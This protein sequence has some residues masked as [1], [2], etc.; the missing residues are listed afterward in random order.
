M[1]N[2]LTTLEEFAYRSNLSVSECKW[3]YDKIIENN[4]DPSNFYAIK[5]DNKAILV[6]K[7]TFILSLIIDKIDYYQVDIVKHEVMGECAVAK[8]KRKDFSE[9]FIW[10]FPLASYKTQYEANKYFMLRKACLV[11][12]ARILF[13]DVFHN[14]TLTF[15]DEAE[16]ASDS[17]I[18]TNTEKQKKDSVLPEQKINNEHSLSKNNISVESL[19]REVRDL[20]RKLNSNEGLFD[21]MSSLLYQKKYSEIDENKKIEVLRHMKASLQDSATQA[22]AS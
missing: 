15:Y 4:L 22:S 17:S 3:I 16:L 19:E 9:V 6:A 20:I 10:H 21:N 2:S 7:Y 14:Y 8:I 13:P 5:S 18:E 12:A 11:Q 1:K